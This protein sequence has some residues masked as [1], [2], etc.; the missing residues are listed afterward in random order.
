MENGNPSLSFFDL[1]SDEKPTTPFLTLELP[2]DGG[3]EGGSLRIRLNVG[4][5]IYPGPELR[6]QVPFFVDPSQQ[7][8]FMLTFFVDSDGNLVEQPHSITM[9]L[10]VL[11]SWAHAG[12]SW[13][14]WNEWR[15]SPVE[16]P[17]DH[18]YRATF[19]MGS[20]SVTLD[21]DAIQPPA[22]MGTLIPL[23][24]YNLNPRRLM[25]VGWEPSGPHCRGISG[26]WNTVTRIPENWSG[27]RSTEFRVELTSSL[28]M[29]EDGLVIVGRVWS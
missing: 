24:V 15:G 5:P 19:T 1:S 8:I 29:T 23:L 16:V 13:A 22:T 14:G 10:P 21:V 18:P 7:M 11:R 17:I 4:L 9:P 25:R 27:C 12:V 6:V 26:V 20:R 2:D 3:A 28:L